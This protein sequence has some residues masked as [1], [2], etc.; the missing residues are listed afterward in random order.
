[1]AV[2]TINERWLLRGLLD[3][4]CAEC[5]HVGVEIRTRLTVEG[6]V[7]PVDPPSEP[8]ADTSELRFRLHLEAGSQQT[9]IECV[10]CKALVKFGNSAEVI[11]DASTE[12]EGSD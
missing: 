3:L 7:V 9:E 10:A 1:M 6:E 2:A 11:Q 5:G 8:Y 4:Q 12:R